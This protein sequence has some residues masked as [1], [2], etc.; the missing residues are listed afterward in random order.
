MASKSGE[1]VS[2]EVFPDCYQEII[3]EAAAATEDLL[4]TKT[5]GRYE[6]EYEEFCNWRR[7]RKVE[8][9]NEDIL[10][11]YVSGLSKNFAPNSLWTKIS[12]LKTCLKLRD[13]IDISR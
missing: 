4:P 6:K 2:L 5:K 12:M 3:D 7:S 1:N 11:C 9:V 13:N 8:G 10:L